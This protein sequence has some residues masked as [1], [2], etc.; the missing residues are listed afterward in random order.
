MADQNSQS[1]PLKQKIKLALFHFELLIL[2]ALAHRLCG[3][4]GSSNYAQLI[5]VI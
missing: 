1:Y 2:T 5:V 4:I 3:T